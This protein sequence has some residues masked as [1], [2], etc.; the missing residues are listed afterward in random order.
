MI[1]RR[2][3]LVGGFAVGV[4]GLAGFPARAEEGF[5]AYSEAALAKAF[6]TGRPV[7]VHVHADW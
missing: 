7:L 5:A 3:A 4:L 2:G 1:S 6:K